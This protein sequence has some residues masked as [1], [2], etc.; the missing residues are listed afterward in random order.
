MGH[1]VQDP[2]KRDVILVKD[3]LVDVTLDNILLIDL[4]L[5]MALLTDFYE[6]IINN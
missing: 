6:M 4:T 5:C 2:I 3:F 1:V